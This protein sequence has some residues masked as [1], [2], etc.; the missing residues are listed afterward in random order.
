[1]KN[2]SDTEINTEILIKTVNFSHDLHD[3]ETENMPH[4]IGYK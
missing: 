4:I 3:L 1:M 2:D